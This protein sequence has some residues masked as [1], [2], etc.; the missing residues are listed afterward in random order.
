MGVFPFWARRLIVTMEG[1]CRPGLDVTPAPCDTMVVCPPTWEWSSDTGG[2]LDKGVTQK[3]PQPD[4]WSPLPLGVSV[5]PDVTFWGG[6]RPP[7]SRV[8]PNPHVV[9][10]GGHPTNIHETLLPNPVG[11]RGSVLE[12]RRG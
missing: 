8:S 7:P 6:V 4:F 12:G 11:G 5:P 2:L 10:E 1:A 9:K 3:S